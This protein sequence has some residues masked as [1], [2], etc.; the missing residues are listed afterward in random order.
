MDAEKIFISRIDEVNTRFYD[1]LEKKD[2]LPQ[3][4]YGRREVAD[5]IA[6]RRDYSL[7]CFRALV[8]APIDSSQGM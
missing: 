3:D 5:T 1:L 8:S 6:N 4:I 7:K 2:M